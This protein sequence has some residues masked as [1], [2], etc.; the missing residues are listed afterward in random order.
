MAL[1][2]ASSSAIRKS[3]LEAA[4]LAF[5]ALPAGIDEQ[6]VKQ[7]LRSPREIA[8]ELAKAKATAVSADP[9]DWVIGSDSIVSVD[10]RLFD[11][12]RSRDDAAAHLRFFSGKAMQLT[13]AVALARA[14]RVDWSHAESATLH[15]RHLGEKFVDKIEEPALLFAQCSILGQ[16]APCLP[17]HPHWRRIEPLPAK[18]GKQGLGLPSVRR[19]ARRRGHPLFSLIIYLEIRL[20][21]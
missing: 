21:M 1:I 2:L 11:K 16:V 18:H 8:L 9:G 13:S 17:H 5:E 19:S 3:M 10:G 15:V 7:R 4:G 6:A 12:P 14:G 20:M